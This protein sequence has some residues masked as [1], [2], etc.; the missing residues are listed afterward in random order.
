MSCFGAVG[1]VWACSGGDNLH[2]G[3]SGS[4][5]DGIADTE[6]VVIIVALTVVAILI[7]WQ[8]AAANGYKAATLALIGTVLMESS[9]YHVLFGEGVG[10]SQPSPYLD[11]INSRAFTVT[12]LTVVAA[13]CA[14]WLLV[15][16]CNTGRWC[17]P[18]SGVRW[19]GTAYSFSAAIVGGVSTY[20]GLL[21]SAGQNPNIMYGIFDVAGIFLG[22]IIVYVAATTEVYARQK[23]V[24]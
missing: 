20:D 1:G 12:T 10:R 17:G 24:P 8:V 16:F 6:E 4:L 18:H 3:A 7:V 23:E 14:S 13:F 15:G 22:M 11:A 21:R 19:L 5:G 2:N 9:I